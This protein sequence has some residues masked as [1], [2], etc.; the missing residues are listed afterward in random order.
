MLIIKKKNIYICNVS[1]N[2]NKMFTKSYNILL[3]LKQLTFIN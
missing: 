1:A 2:A 3:S